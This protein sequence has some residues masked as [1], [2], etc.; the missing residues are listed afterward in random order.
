MTTVSI[1]DGAST[2]FWHDLWNG[3]AIAHAFPELFS[4]S[5][6]PRVIVRHLAL[7]NPISQHFHLPLSTQAYQQYQGLIAMIQNVQN[8][9]DPD[10]WIYNWGNAKFSTGK[11]YKS[12]VG[13]KHT[14]PTYNWLWNSKCQMKYKVSFFWLLLKDRLSTKELLQR[15]NMELDSYTCELCIR[16][17]PETI[18]HLFLRCGF[19]KACW[20]SIGVY[21]LNA[22]NVSQ[23]INRIKQQLSN[24]FFMEIIIIMTWSIWTTINDWIFRE[25]DPTVQNCKRKFI[26]ECSLLKYRLKSDHLP[27]LETWLQRIS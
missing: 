7:L 14:H 2:L 22:R 25:V 1:K 11:A 12:L 23:N 15:K 26:E 5:R 24:S 19:A 4:F 8:Q 21:T 18:P 6:N 13:H 20:E 9:Q 17:R 16:Q 10:L 27:L 3:Q